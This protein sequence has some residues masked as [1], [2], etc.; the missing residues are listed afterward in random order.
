VKAWMY[1]LAFRLARFVV[2]AD[3]KTTLQSIDESRDTVQ[4]L[5]G[6]GERGA[7]VRSSRGREV[8]ARPAS[9]QSERS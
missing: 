3:G 8:P 4:K 7:A 6:G 2:I 5:G 9:G 1:G